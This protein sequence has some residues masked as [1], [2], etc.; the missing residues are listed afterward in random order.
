MAESGIFE[1]PNCG[2]ENT[3]NGGNKYLE[4]SLSGQWIKLA[5]V[6]LEDHCPCSIVDYYEKCAPL[7]PRHISQFRKQEKTQLNLARS[8]LFRLKSNRRR[9]AKV[10]ICGDMIEVIRGKKTVKY[11]HSWI[12]KTREIGDQIDLHKLGFDYL[13]R[14]A[15]AGHLRR[16]GYVC[17]GNFVYEY[18]GSPAGKTAK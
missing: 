12:P 18:A 14:Q 10:K 7:M 1:R 15:T 17:V 9:E 4:L 2:S 5:T 3:G 11:D 6:W 8:A 16:L 13:R